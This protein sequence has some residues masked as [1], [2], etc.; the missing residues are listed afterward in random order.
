VTLILNIMDDIQKI[1]KLSELNAELE[2][3]EEK[4]SDKN[5]KYD[6]QSSP[7]IEHWQKHQ[8]PEASQ[9]GRIGREI[10]MLLTPEF[11]DLPDFG[12][13]MSLKD[14][15]ANVACGGFIDYDGYGHYIKDGKESNI[16]IYPSDIRHGSI[17]DDFDTIIW[18]NR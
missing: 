4:L 11:H 8:Q 3:L 2:V 5:D 7:S 6:F 13:V 16:E 14:F 17:R 15:K 1:K 10:R 12:D 9:I 18:Y